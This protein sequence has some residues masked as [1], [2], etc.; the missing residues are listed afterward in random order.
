MITGFGELSRRAGITV[1]KASYALAAL[2]T[3]DH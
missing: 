2:L 1:T 3:G